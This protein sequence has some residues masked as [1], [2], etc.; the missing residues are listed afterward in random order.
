MEYGSERSRSINF[1]IGGICGT[2]RRHNDESPSV[3]TEPHCGDSREQTLCDTY[4]Q[5][6]GVSNICQLVVCSTR[7]LVRHGL[8]PTVR[9]GGG[10]GEGRKRRKLLTYCPLASLSDALGGAIDAIGGCARR[11][12]F[13]VLVS[14]TPA[15]RVP[16]SSC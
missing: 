13:R 5:L 14:S 3:S 1:T 12:E 4:L 15:S 9:P 16:R 7:D 6:A 11:R 2:K 10:G 8:D